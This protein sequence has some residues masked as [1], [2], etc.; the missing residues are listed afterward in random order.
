[1]A[2]IVGCGSNG[3]ND[4][5]KD[6]S[7]KRTSSNTFEIYDHDSYPNRHVDETCETIDMVVVDLDTPGD[8]YKWLNVTCGPKQQPSPTPIPT[9]DPYAP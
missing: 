2:M 3:G 9:V 7:I 8:A 5:G 6:V 4:S 1:M